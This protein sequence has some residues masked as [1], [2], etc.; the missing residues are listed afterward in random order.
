M[1]TKLQTKEIFPENYIKSATAED[2]SKDTSVLENMQKDFAIRVYCT[3]DGLN[4]FRIYSTIEYNLSQI[5]PVLENMGFKVINQKTYELDFDSKIIYMQDYALSN[6]S[7]ECIVATNENHISKIEEGLKLILHKDIINDELNA[8]LNI[9]S[10]NAYEIKV[11]RALVAYTQQVGTKYSLNAIRKMYTLNVNLAELIVQAFDAKFNPEL[12]REESTEKFI[13]V[14]QKFNYDL[15]NVASLD[16]EIVLKNSF[17]LVKAMLR[18]NYYSIDRLEDGLAFKFDSKEVPNLPKPYPMFE[19]FVYHKDVQGV[20]LRGG[21]V[22]R[23]GLR[24]SDRAA[25]FRSE[26]LGLVK[27]QITK[28]SVIVPTGSKGGF[29]VRRSLDGL[30]REDF[31]NAGI[32]CY[33]IFITSLLSITD[34]IVNGK[35]ITPKGIVRYDEQDPYL[36]VA[37]DK[38]TATFSNI[39]NGLAIDHGFWLKDAFAS[40]GEFGYD[41]KKMGITAK[42][43]WESVKR[44]FRHFDLDTQNQNFDVIGIGGMAGDVFGNGM[45]LSP[46]INLVAAFN[47]LSIFIDPTPDVEKSYAERQRLFDTVESWNEYNEDLIS[48]GGGVFLRTSKS[49]SITPEMKAKFAIKED[50]LTP[51]E[52]IVRLMKA[53]VDLIWNG[54]IGTFVKSSLEDNIDV[55]DRANDNIRI[56]GKD[57]QA[58]V[59]GEGGNLGFTQLGRI[60]FNNHGGKI[61]TDAIDNSAGVSCSDKEV[62]IKILLEAAIENGSLKAEDRNELLESMTQDVEDMVL[63]DNYYQGSLLDIEEAN[64]SSNVNYY[65]DL[66]DNLEKKGSLDRD[67][68]NL[69]SN[70]ELDERLFHNKKVISS[71]ELSVLLA[72]AKIDLTEK[73]VVSSLVKAPNVER[74]LENYF[75]KGLSKFDSE[76]KNHKLRDDIIATQLANYIINKMGLAFVVKMQSQ[77]VSNVEDIVRSFLIAEKVFDLPKIYNAIDS[78]D[79]KVNAS[80]QIELISKLQEILETQCLWFVRNLEKPLHIVNCVD[81]LNCVLNKASFNSSFNLDDADEAKIKDVLA[82]LES[83]QEDLDSAFMSYKLMKDFDVVNSL[84]NEVSERMALSSLI[85]GVKS[86]KTNNTWEEI[87]SKEFIN[88][89]Q[90]LKASLAEDVI[91][92]DLSLNEYVTSKHIVLRDFRAKV[93][94]LDDVDFNY[95]VVKVLVSRLR[96][97]LS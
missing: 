39:A 65:K 18:T 72:Y 4:H 11:L 69:P 60:E 24:W 61:Y 80:V 1:Q 38:G 41:H 35:I 5:I 13:K 43:A 81:L 31:Q 86:I 44:H 22:A 36:V 67:V 2:I 9:S 42:G 59:I 14:E 50:E 55:P 33:K 12:S 21:K 53:P 37:A 92:S 90:S 89:L 79:N 47:H 25:D 75:P 91:K 97:L 84:F 32:E 48:K 85:G 87:A 56:N 6:E 73:L 34:N 74:F 58:K 8:L 64:A 63:A 51:D 96:S 27:T 71:P 66:M 77:S 95:S 70:L 40:G 26:I 88:E 54:G 23:G 3:K 52:L 7:Q 19:I 62:N 29:V 10:L 82:K 15:Q 28:N 49:I 30:S 17:K 45:L 76:V 94:S 68:E 83:I 46:K 20:H 78:L 16:E 57:L 93:R